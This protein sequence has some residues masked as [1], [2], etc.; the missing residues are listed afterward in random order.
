MSGEIHRLRER[1]G[2]SEK[3]TINLGFVD[4]GHI[5]LLVREGFYSNR[6][7]FIRTAIRNQLASHADAVKQSIVRRT[8][9]LGLRR[10][11]REEL[12]AAKAKG[13][14]LSIQVVGLATIDDDV[15]PELALAAIEFDHRPRRSPRQQSRQG[16]A[17]RSHPVT[18]RALIH[19]NKD[20]AM[21]SDFSAA[22]RRAAE[23]T[24]AQNV[25][26]ATRVIQRALMGRR[27]VAP[28]AE[29]PRESARLLQP[30]S[31][32]EAAAAAEPSGE[33][34]PTA[35]AP[36]AADMRRGGRTRRPL[37]EVLRLLREADLPGVARGRP[38]PR[39]RKAPQVPVPDGAAYLTR[40]FACPAGS[41]DYKLY[42]PAHA[43]GRTLPLVVMLHGCTQNPDDFALG[44]AMN[45][46]AE[47]HGVIVAYPWQP[48]SANPSAC[49]NWFSPAHQMR[50]E[51]EPG[52]I[53]G[54]TRAVMG[55]FAVD[56]E[57]VYVAGLSAGGAMAAIMGALYP[58]LY[59]AAGVHSG[60]PHGVRRR[61]AFGICGHA[62]D[63]ESGGAARRGRARAKERRSHHR[64]SRRERQDGRS[65][66]RR[67]DPRGRSRRPRRSCAR[68]PPRR[69][70]RRT[71]LYPHHRHRRARRSARGILGDRRTGPRLVRGQ[72]G[73]FVHGPARARR[74]ARNAAVLPRGDGEAVHALI[75]VAGA[76]RKKGRPRRGGWSASA[77]ATACSAGI[78]GCSGRAFWRSRARSSA[79]PRGA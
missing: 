77:A 41:R 71:R 4:L 60:L 66:E 13:D 20:P 43:E 25:I 39:R 70:R 18:D 52:I 6:T 68:N 37:G 59:A 58:E 34:A 38:P 15:T 57:R 28:P 1:P 74:L 67:G 3:I 61:R 40:T 35:K 29:E 65:L 8:L 50:D 45:R 12:E 75:G 32:A 55:E 49:W 79:A 22:M 54:I 36:G 63:G 21:K 27:N 72:P 19:T 46:L 64:L 7:D 42:V 26:E 24:R 17:R 78:R 23:L 33:E 56:P 14:R 51:G 30:P 73:R 10:Y 48:A 62:R 11:S 76:R 16:G 2:D 5:D 9:E 69:L 44:T 47:E 53:A 31:F